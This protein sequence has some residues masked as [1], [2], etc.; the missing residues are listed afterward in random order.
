MRVGSTL[1]TAAITIL[2]A[3]ALSWLLP[4]AWQPEQA[5]AQVGVGIAIAFLVFGIVVIGFIESK[6]GNEQGGQEQSE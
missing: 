3:S 4:K 6:R 5:D 1:A 2:V